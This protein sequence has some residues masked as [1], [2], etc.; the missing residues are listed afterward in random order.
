MF[1]SFSTAAFL[2]DPVSSLLPAGAVAELV[3]LKVLISL[4]VLIPISLYLAVVT[5]LSRFASDSE[6]V[7]AHALRVPPS[8]VG[9]AVVAVSASLAIVVAALS[10]FARPWAYGEL[11][12]ASA[13]AEGRLDVDAMRPGTFYV[14]RDGDRVVFFSRQDAPGASAQDVFVQSWRG[15]QME[16]IHARLA[17]RTTRRAAD[18]SAPISLRDAHIYRFDPY[19]AGDDR[20]LQAQD[21]TVDPDDQPA[22]SPDEDAVTQSSRRLLASDAPASVAEMQWRWSTGVSTLLLGLLAIPMSRVR[23]RQARVTRFGTAILIYVAYYMLFTSARTW[24]QHGAV[25]AFPGVWWVPAMLGMLV[26]ASLTAPGRHFGEGF[27][28]A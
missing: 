7:A 17:S 25:P 11:H 26:L 20:V 16:V 22:T 5:A 23:P 9:S 24:V 15:P 3:G 21:M 28:R 1:A 6:L 18:G 13:R 10:L 14:G 2:G 4:E 8:R 19:G 27:R 12:A